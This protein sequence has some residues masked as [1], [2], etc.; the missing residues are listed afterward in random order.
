MSLKEIIELLKRL[1]H[2]VHDETVIKL[3]MAIESLEQEIN[4]RADNSP[5]VNNYERR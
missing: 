4:G 1:K 5:T 3:D 2:H